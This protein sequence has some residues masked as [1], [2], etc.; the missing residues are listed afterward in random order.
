[1]LKKAY[2]VETKLACIEMKK[3]GKSNKVIT[4]KVLEEL[5]EVEQLRLQV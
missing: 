3:A 5:S 4:V 1:M 2:S